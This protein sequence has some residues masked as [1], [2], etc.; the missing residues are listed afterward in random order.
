MKK[1]IEFL[2]KNKRMIGACIVVALLMTLLVLICT[3]RG[4]ISEIEISAL[5]ANILKLASCLGI[6]FIVFVCSIF[7]S[8]GTLKAIDSGVLDRA[9]VFLGKRITMRLDK[10]NHNIIYYN[11]TY[12]LYDVLSKHSSEFGVSVPDR[13]S[14]LADGDCFRVKDG[15]WHYRF[16][17]IA[18]SVPKFFNSDL[19]V[20]I[21]GYLNQETQLGL[22]MLNAF[23]NGE[24]SIYV[25]KAYYD[26]N[27]FK[28]IIELLYIDS[29][30]AFK[31]YKKATAHADYYK[32]HEKYIRKL[33]SC[34]SRKGIL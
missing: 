33:L 11:L 24:H 31:Y 32:G 28:L 7:L 29:D 20:I 30:S 17:I 25:T 13:K 8:I 15:E 27:S 14:L 12:P 5:K 21:Q 3:I 9:E 6:F 10:R 1:I 22:S 2:K 34:M 26:N 4:G 23:Y 18:P 19:K 16:E